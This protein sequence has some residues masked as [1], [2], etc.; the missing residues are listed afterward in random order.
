MR[1][2]FLIL[3]HR[4]ATQLLRLINTIRRELPDSPIVVHHDEFAA[5]L[6]RSLLDFDDNAF[7]LTIGTPISWATSA[8][9]MLT[10]SACPGWARTSTSTMSSCC[11]ARITRSSH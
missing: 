9:L 4:P 8:W 3:N 5:G 7:L 6:S 10:G 1:I 2:A 11:P